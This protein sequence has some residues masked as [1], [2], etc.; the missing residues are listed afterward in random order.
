MGAGNFNF[1]S[2]EV[3]IAQGLNLE[4]LICKTLTYV[5]IYCQEL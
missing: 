4:N 2:I 3:I 1:F 5:H